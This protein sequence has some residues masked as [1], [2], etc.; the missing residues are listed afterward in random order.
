M[1][2]IFTKTVIVFLVLFLASNILVSSNP[3]KIRINYDNIQI[4]KNIIE[5]STLMMAIKNI[6]IINNKI[7]LT[8]DL[9][10][11]RLGKGD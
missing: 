5:Y 9:P 11:I 7:I 8:G 4:K 1:K 6:L 10:S 3:Q 2:K